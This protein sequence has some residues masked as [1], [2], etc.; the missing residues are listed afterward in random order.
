MTVLIYSYREEPTPITFATQD[1]L[2]KVLPDQTVSITHTIETD[3][4]QSDTPFTLVYPGGYLFDMMKNH[5]GRNTRGSKRNKSHEALD[6]GANLFGICAGA[7]Y[8]CNK[9]MAGRD[10]SSPYSLGTQNYTLKQHIIDNNMF[11]GTL[12]RVNAAAIGPCFESKTGAP[13]H[14]IEISRPN[15]GGVF[16]SLFWKGPA[17]FKSD[18]SD[19]FLGEEVV[20]NYVIEDKDRIN[21]NLREENV[22]YLGVKSDKH[23]SSLVIKESLAA[24]LNIRSKNSHYIL[25]GFHPELAAQATTFLPHYERQYSVANRD[26]LCSSETQRNNYEFLDQLVT[27]FK[28]KPEPF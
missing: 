17:F 21:L 3:D 28:T 10:P 24:A 23:L 19:K 26:V 2:Q 11:N 12:E 27:P 22:S 8:A 6:N 13:I 20:A 14:S 18:F 15:D 25:T 16:N 7:F 9:V 4:I 5:G 1:I